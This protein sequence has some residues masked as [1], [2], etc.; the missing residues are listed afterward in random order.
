MTA[1]IQA[2]STY[3]TQIPSLNSLGFKFSPIATG[4]ISDGVTTTAGYQVNTSF[5]TGKVTLLG[6]TSRVL[7]F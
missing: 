7:T 3:S 5:Q 2:P 4:T 1:A 6:L